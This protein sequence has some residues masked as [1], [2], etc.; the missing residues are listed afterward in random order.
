MRPP[1]Y[2]PSFVGGNGPC[3]T[4]PLVV[5]FADERNAVFLNAA[6]F[7]EL[8]AELDGLPTQRSRGPSPIRRTLMTRAFYSRDAAEVEAVFRG[9]DRRELRDEGLPVWA[10][11]DVAEQLGRL[12]EA[13]VERVML[14]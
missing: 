2:R 12:E 14:Q 8:S 6:R 10:T 5:R 3:R 1:V 9:R 7:A 11:D 4:L 13:G